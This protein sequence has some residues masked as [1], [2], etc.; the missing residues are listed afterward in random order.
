M[1]QRAEK[2]ERGQKV[3]VYRRRPGLQTV[4]FL[5]QDQA[6]VECY[7]RCAEGGWRL[8]EVSGDN[9]SLHLPALGFDRALTELYRD[10]PDKETA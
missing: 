7:T 4:R 10:L 8:T 1:G 3:A 2:P 9:A 6:H 5:G